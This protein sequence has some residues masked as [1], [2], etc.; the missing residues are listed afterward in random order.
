MPT[1]SRREIIKGIPESIDVMKH[2]ISVSTSRRPILAGGTVAGASMTAVLMLPAATRAELVLAD[3][4]SNV[5]PSMQRQGSEFLNSGYGSSSP[6][7]AQVVRKLPAAP[8][9]FHSAKRNPLHKLFGNF[10]PNGR[11]FL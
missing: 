1:T 7:E 9:A 3:L 8:A 6:H 2:G 4:P 10:T 11:F 5:S